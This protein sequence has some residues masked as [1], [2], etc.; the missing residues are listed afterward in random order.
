MA[1]YRV[2]GAV[3]VVKLSDGGERYVSHGT[4]LP[5][6]ADK[7]HLNHLVQVGLVEPVDV[8]VSAVVVDGG[9]EVTPDADQP[10][11]E[12]GQADF[13]G[14]NLDELRGYAA[15]HGIDLGG[16]TRKADIIAVLQAQ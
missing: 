6:D 10:P 8:K 16:A 2:K 3:A 15:E 9:T 1:K 14:L 13:D 7:D 12:D 11:A 5:A 4:F